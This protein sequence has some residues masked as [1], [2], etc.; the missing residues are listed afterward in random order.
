MLETVKTGDVKHKKWDKLEGQLED[1]IKS[2]MN[3]NG[4]INKSLSELFKEFAETHN[5]TVSSTSFYYYNCGLK[6]RIFGSNEPNNIEETNAD[7]NEELNINEEIERLI[8]YI[9]N[10]FNIDVSEDSA[11]MIKEMVKEAGVVSTLLTINEVIEDYD[12]L[13][14]SFII[15]REA[16]SRL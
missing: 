5:T 10:N 8:K 1:F 11:S 13:D 9:K 6:E 2:N 15:I 3:Q 14:M 12:K 4:Q 7:N 16:K